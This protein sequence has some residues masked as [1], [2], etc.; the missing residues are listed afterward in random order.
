[1]TASHYYEYKISID[2]TCIR[3]IIILIHTMRKVGSVIITFY[4]ISS[5]AGFLLDV[6]LST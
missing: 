6:N 1:M 5:N 4:D 2:Y 3:L